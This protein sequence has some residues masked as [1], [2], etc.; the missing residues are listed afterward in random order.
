M[1]MR[2]NLE[3]FIVERLLEL[4]PSLSDSAGSAIYAKVVY[5]L[6]K[7]LGA[8]PM[9][10]DVEKFIT[11]RLA[12]EFPNLDGLS[13]GSVFR[14]M[15]VLPLITILEPLRVEVDFARKQGSLADVDALAESEMDALLDNIFAT[16]VTGGY[17]I[18]S[19]R[20]FFSTPQAFSVDSSIV[21]HTVKNVEF[22]PTSPT[23]FLVSDL[24]RSGAL[25]YVDIPVRSVLK[26]EDAQVGVDEIKFARG[27]AG[28]ARVT[29]LSASSGGVSPETNLAFV[30]RAQQGLSERSLNTER[31]IATNL[32][33]A[34]DGIV[35]IDVVGY[36]EPEM[37]RDILQGTSNLQTAEA[38]GAYVGWAQTLD[39]V[40]LVPGIP[41]TNKI[42][43]DSTAFPEV[44]TAAV[45]GNYIRISDAG[46]LFEGVLSRPRRIASVTPVGAI[47]TIVLDDFELYSATGGPTQFTINNVDP[48]QVS[49]AGFNRYARQGSQYSMV[50][51]DGLVD[52]VIG[53][54]L[55]F[56]EQVH[57]ALANIP[58]TAIPGRDFLLVQ[59]LDADPITALD[60]PCT[61]CY[62]I[63]KVHDGSTL[64]L[65]RL[66]SFLTHR[67]KVSSTSFVFTPDL[68][69]MAESEGVR[70][71]A[72]GSPKLS[73]NTPARNDGISFDPYGRAP[74]VTLTKGAVTGDPCT[75]E[76]EGTQATWASRG[77]VAGQYIALAFPDPLHDGS[78]TGANDLTAH[79]LEWHAWGI[80]TNVAGV[81]LTVEGVDWEALDATV[82]L[83]FA[84][85]TFPLMWTVYRGQIETIAPDGTVFPSYDE[86]MLV[87]AYRMDPLAAPTG[88]VHRPGI[89]RYDVATGGFKADYPITENKDWSGVQ[90]VWIRLGR[91]IV[92]AEVD[93]SDSPAKK[94]L[95]A[96]L[97][98]MD[99][100]P[101]VGPHP[102]TAYSKQRFPTLESVTDIYLAAG[103]LD[104][105][106]G[107]VALPVQE[108][109]TA[110]SSPAGTIGVL[111]TAA[112]SPNTGRMAG[113]LLPVG[114]VGKQVLFFTPA[115]AQSATGGIVV[116]GM[117]GSVPFPE[118]FGAGLVI[119]SDAIHLGGLTDMYV[120]GSTTITAV[121][122]PIR[123]QPASP[124]PNDTEVLFSGTDGQVLAAETRSF[125]SSTLI[126]QAKNYMGLGA[127]DDGHLGDL[128]VELIDMDPLVVAPGS[129]RIVHGILDPVN[130]AGVRVDTTLTA[131]ADTPATLRWRVLRKC[132]TSLVD[133]LRVLQEGSN[134]KAVANEMKVSSVSGFTFTDNP[135]TTPV[136]LR[137]AEGSGL[138]SGEYRITNKSAT[139]LS[140]DRAVVETV[141]G[142]TYQVY[143]K[144]LERVATPLV[145]VSRVELTGDLAG[146]SVP[147]RHPVD[148]VASSFAGLNNDPVA[149]TCTLSN[150]G[151]YL[152]LDVVSPVLAS[153]PSDIGE[154]D[155]VR[156][157]DFSGNSRHFYITSRVDG[158]SVV[159]TLD[160]ELLPAPAG[161][162]TLHDFTVGHP[163]V[164]TVDLLFTDPT[165]FE[166]NS[167]ETADGLT[168]FSF[169]NAPGQE[170]RFR[171]SPAESAVVYLSDET[172]TAVEVVSAGPNTG[173]AVVD[174]A[175]PF[176][177]SGVQ[178]G[179]VIQFLTQ[180][181]VSSPVFSDAERAALPPPSIA[182]HT[183]VL[184][185]E[186]VEYAITMAG[187]GQLSLQTVVDNINQQAG[188]V[189]QASIEGSANNWTLSLA[190]RLTV[191]ITNLGTPGILTALRLAAVSNVLSETKTITAIEYDF[192]SQ[193]TLL[194]WA[195]VYAAA[196]APVFIQITRPGQQRLYPADMVQ[197]DTGLWMGRLR[198]TSYDPFETEQVEAGQQLAV[199][200]YRSLGYDLQVDPDLVNYSYS[201]AE[202]VAIQ[203]TSIMLDTDA[204][205]LVGALALPGVDVAV[206]YEHSPLARA[207]QEYVLSPTVRV[208]NH[209]PLVRHYLPAYA[210]MAVTYTGTVTDSELL[211]K[212]SG[213]L[214]SRYPNLPIEVF[215]LVTVLERAGA[216]Y[217]AFPQQVAFLTYGDDRVVRVI[218]S[219]DVVR[220]GKKYHIMESTD[221]ITIQAG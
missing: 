119:E 157:D 131:P 166:A 69:L 189:V 20:V 154:N 112:A 94:L 30:E 62:P 184:R 147:Y 212:I 64:S 138:N 186:G 124:T 106:R 13:P 54:P 197:Q 183:L 130:G 22:I 38:P 215:D 132:T 213:Y 146:V 201:T 26:T 70:V 216:D 210:L 77:V 42:T 17:A 27:L 25:Y 49:G 90:G 177:P 188:T 162:P 98:N 151:G 45:V 182:G 160:R 167:V 68:N 123:L 2:T 122:D 56:D 141:S 221:L 144:Q 176:L 23:N 168:M 208:T 92:D 155:V 14:D 134:L 206:T 100:W 11:S 170:L 118:Q 114:L 164:G 51:R 81:T 97:L 53:A 35:S 66:D 33:N 116:S 209:N 73:V 178:V 28:V 195:G 82:V 32:R 107:L 63:H 4:D 74:G 101:V 121:A 59:L 8:D 55:P 127:L 120:K 153:F 60:Q 200:G 58:T 199:E 129:F 198:L 65:S 39:T 34:F 85:N 175:S 171:P 165:Y 137:I 145:R 194:K 140:L 16:R 205:S 220:L 9:T 202:K 88:L 126:T 181:L 71:V 179:D 102:L 218:R 173:L 161:S 135:A 193:G 72:F 96:I 86:Q 219:D 103:P 15:F 61:R 159:L 185:I 3:R 214:G 172:D 163:G 24:R 95:S 29:N 148:A 44:V 115:S 67:E 46:G 18:T 6:V 1:S 190:S 104:V 192:T 169:E 21:F 125:F 139:I 142:L 105:V 136:F 7:R 204:T 91:S 211:G 128:V 89:S 99:D 78:L 207:I 187:T 57:V 10:V 48:A 180:V 41:V 87:P 47:Y 191:E 196:T 217:V 149:G 5:P 52:Y 93:G 110:I 113:Y 158:V 150:V 12:D 109:K 108:G 174:V 31:G 76:L 203:V 80:I 152:T 117:P 37:Q 75:V 43:L 36:G 111:T 133:P 50:V 84:A 156:L 19:V 40:E 83:P 79:P 143:T